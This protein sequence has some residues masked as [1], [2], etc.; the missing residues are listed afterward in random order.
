ME[1]ENLPWNTTLETINEELWDKIAGSKEK[2]NPGYL[3]ECEV[4]GIKVD[5]LCEANEALPLLVAVEDLAAD[6]EEPKLSLV[7]ML[8]LATTFQ[9]KEGKEVQGEWGKCSVG[10]A[11]SALV[12][13]ELLLEALLAGAAVPLKAMRKVV[14]GTEWLCNG[15]P[16]DSK[17]ECVVLGENLEVLLLKDMSAGSE[18]D[19]P[20]GSVLSEGFVGPG[21]KDET[22]K[23]EFLEAG[24]KCTAPEKAENLKGESVAN[25]CKKAVKVE[26]ENLPWNTTL[27]TINEELWDKI[28]GSKEKSNPGYLTECE[29]E[30][31]KVDD[32]CEANE[33]LPLLVAVEDLAADS[34]E[35]KLSLVDMLFLATTFQEKEGK[36]VQG[37]WGKC[38]VG[39]AN[40][41]LV[42]G[43][44]LLEALLAGAAVPLEADK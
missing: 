26:A 40:S 10:G 4:E 14:E 19:C 30:G 34:E 27:E 41:A 33:A 38:S 2:S 36:E 1:A 9:E 11:N 25:A 31:I 23:V 15:E 12:V 21:A 37:E 17:S 16:V 42:V 43:E 39:G 22:T 28:A 29:V 44:L 7:D 8:F 6:S 20:V 35:P 13:G 3:T 18:V 32:L 24:A 5:D